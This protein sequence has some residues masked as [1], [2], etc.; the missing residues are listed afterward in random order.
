MVGPI[1]LAVAALVLASAGYQAILALAEGLYHFELLIAS[2]PVVVICLA[3][4]VLPTFYRREIGTGTVVAVACVAGWAQV[5]ALAGSRPFHYFEPTTLLLSALPFVGI[6][7][8]L[9]LGW[10]AGAGRWGKGLLLLATIVQLLTA[11]FVVS[12]SHKPGIDVYMFHQDSAAA[13]LQGTNPYAITFP[14][15]YLEP[16]GLPSRFY[17]LDVQQDGRVMFG[18]PY[19]PMS[20]WMYLPSYWLTGESRYAHAMAFALA[21]LGIGL[22]S[23]GRIA[24]MAAILL[25]TAPA[26]WIVIESAWTEPFI[27]LA[28][29]GVALAAI[30]APMMLP[31][32]LGIFFSLK[33]YNIIFVPLLWLILPRPLAWGSSIRFFAIMIATGAAVSLPLAVWDWAEFW[34]SNVTIQVKQPFRFDAFSYLAIFA[35]AHPLT[36]KPPGWWSAIAFL[37][38]V[39]TWAALLWR[40]PRNIAGFTLAIGLTSIVFLFSNRQAFMNYHTFAAGAILLAVACIEAMRE[41]ESQTSPHP[42][43]LP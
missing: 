34:N 29:V 41:R 13:I 15:P 27:L 26:Q 39:P 37:L 7:V 30:R 19:P 14:N 35:N 31:V 10:A 9:L 6:S 42:L 28:L 3:A 32:A 17:S 23:R 1:P 33:Q 16:G 8:V 4:G 40:M 5:L 24:T 36:W 18:F 11:W 43:P 22:V 20:M 21:G 25:L 38:L 2:I 12:W